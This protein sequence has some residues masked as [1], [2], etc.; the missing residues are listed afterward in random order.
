[1]TGAAGFIGS[2]V[3]RALVESTAW[4]VVAVV[5][6]GSDRDRL[7]PVA[8]AA[9]SGR[10]SI[11]EV[12]LA[13]PGAVAALLARTQPQSIAHLAVD[14][15]VHNDLSASEVD[16]IALA[17]I[18]AMVGG[19]VRPSRFVH[20]SSVWV[21]PAG[22]RLDEACTTD[23]QLPYAHVKCAEEALV[24][25]VAGAAGVEW[26]TLRLFN[27]FGR[28]EPV[29]RLLPALVDHLRRGEPY[30]LARPERVRDFSPVE[31]MAA[32]YV[33]ALAAPGAAANR[34]YHIASGVGIS[35]RAFA[36]TVAA[37]LD[38]DPAL[39]VA[40]DHVPAD[41]YLP[42]Q[43]GD[44]TLAASRRGWVAPGD[45]RPAIGDATRWWSTRLAGAS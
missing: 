37:E 2:A 15:A 45:P 34:L 41:A 7:A 44:P 38:A 26:F 31:A 23:P 35:L 16:R 6:P 42:V 30:A 9:G 24:R 33:S 4:D 22:D 1:V 36:D 13:D 43:V 29:H 32:A 40:G 19:P 11:A 8:P 12:D 18:R 28:H 20:T 5:R 3:V 25:D 27:V 39:V 14:P 10:C 21:L 17:P